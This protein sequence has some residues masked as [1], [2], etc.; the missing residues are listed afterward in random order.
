MNLR[1]SSYFHKSSILV[2]K[3][4]VVTQAST[5]THLWSPRPA[6]TLTCGH[7]HQ[8]LCS[9]VITQASTRAHL[10]SPRPAPTLT[11]GHPGQHLCSPVVTQ[12]STCAHLWS[13]RP[14]PSLTCDHPGQ[15]LC[16]SPEITQ[17]STA[18]AGLEKVTTSPL[19]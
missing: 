2:A 13:P 5:H 16:S 12:A 11:C 10:W 1:K 7:P 3:A 17:A 6:P 8:H 19:A 15:Y 14:T 9:P 4:P 18:Q